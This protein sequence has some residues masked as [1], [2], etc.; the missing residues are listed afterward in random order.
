MK[1][2]DN[3]GF[4]LVELIIVIAIM[5]VLMGVLAP[6]FIKYVDQ[7]RQQKDASACGEVENA[8]QTALSVEQVYTDFVAAGGTATVTIPAAGGDLT[9]SPDSLITEL[10]K[11]IPKTDAFSSKAFTAAGDQ[12]VTITL[13]DDGTFTITNT[14]DTIIHPTT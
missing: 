7:S 13:A 8:A 2:M 1:K 10:K 4:S 6:Q 9:G 11:I 12:T 5:A 3:K 14:W